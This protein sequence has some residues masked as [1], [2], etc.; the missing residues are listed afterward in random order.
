MGLIVTVCPRARNDAAYS[1]AP[2][3]VVNLRYSM[4]GVNTSQKIGLLI[5][6]PMLTTGPKTRVCSGSP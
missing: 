1:F 2:V 6:Y 4:L 3:R 5:L